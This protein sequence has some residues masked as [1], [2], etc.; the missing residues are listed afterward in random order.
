M[1]C[2]A[3]PCHATPCHATPCHAT[4]R[5]VMSC[6][7]TPD[8]S[9]ESPDGSEI[10]RWSLEVAHTM[11]NVVFSTSRFGN[12]KYGHLEYDNGRV[13]KDVPCWVH[14]N[15]VVVWIRRLRKSPQP[16]L[17]M[18]LGQMAAIPLIL[19]NTS[20]T[21]AENNVNLMAHSIP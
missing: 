5:H 2:H 16:L 15:T 12:L 6:H 7:R 4:S 17:D 9:I 18:S 10:N 11:F 8:M 21:T 3:M 19:S 20:A 14:L 13:A 1:S